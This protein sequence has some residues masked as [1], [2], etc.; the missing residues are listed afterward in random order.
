MF[1]FISF[2]AFYFLLYAIDYSFFSLLCCLRLTVVTFTSRTHLGIPLGLFLLLLLLPLLCSLLQLPLPVLLLLRD[3]GT[4]IPFPSRHFLALDAPQV[5][6]KITSITEQDCLRRLIPATQL[7]TAFFL[8]LLLPGLDLLSLHAFV[9]EVVL[10]GHLAQAQA[11]G[12]GATAAGL[13]EDNQVLPVSTFTDLTEVTRT[14]LLAFAVR[15]G[16]IA[17]QSIPRG[18]LCVDGQAAAVVG[19][20]A[21]VTALEEVA[22]VPPFTDRAGFINHRKNGAT[23]RHNFAGVESHSRIRQGQGLQALVHDPDIDAK[24]EQSFLPHGIGAME[25]AGVWLA[26]LQDIAPEEGLETLRLH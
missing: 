10:L 15:A 4:T 21:M 14:G 20:V 2:L 12:V 9:A 22:A 11:G 24:F 7:T 8:G 23:P 6:L 19:D 26:V 1:K 16:P 18:W 3:T 5:V 13:A 25:E 17:T